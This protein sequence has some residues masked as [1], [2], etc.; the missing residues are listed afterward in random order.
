V[1]ETVKDKHIVDVAMMGSW[2]NALAQIECG[3]TQAKMFS[4]AIEVYTGQIT[5]ELQG[6]KIAVADENT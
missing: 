6:T 3:E 5:V 4:K 1:Y 2:E